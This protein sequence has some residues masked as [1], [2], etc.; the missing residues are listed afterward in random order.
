MGVRNF[1]SYARRSAKA[2]GSKRIVRQ[3]RRLERMVELT[4]ADMNS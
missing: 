2:F 4:L 3:V 1:S